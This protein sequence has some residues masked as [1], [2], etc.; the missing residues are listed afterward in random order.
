MLEVYTITL[1]HHVRRCLHRPN[2]WPPCM[3]KRE[4]EWYGEMRFETQRRLGPRRGMSGGDFALAIDVDVS[5]QISRALESPAPPSASPA[6]R[7]TYN[8][9]VDDEIG[10]QNSLAIQIAMRLLALCCPRSM[11][12][13]TKTHV[14]DLIHKYTA[15]SESHDLDSEDESSPESSEGSQSDSDAE[16]SKASASGAASSGAAPAAMALEKSKCEAAAE[17]ILSGDKT[18]I[19]KALAALAETDKETTAAD[20]AA[21]KTDAMH[22][23]A[24][25]P[26]DV[27]HM[28][29]DYVSTSRLDT[30]KYIH[31]T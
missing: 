13:G 6:A 16:A 30:S 22:L 11:P 18:E 1:L 15:W 14:K 5:L 12:L 21:A 23:P 9:V 8:Q 29:L 27:F 24:V 2:D 10:P 28:I 4:I 17:S 20:P 7:T 31:K 26:L 19:A 25:A 3:G